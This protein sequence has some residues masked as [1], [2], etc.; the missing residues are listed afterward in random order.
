MNMTQF[1]I[2]RKIVLHKTLASGISFSV[3]SLNREMAP[4]RVLW[5]LAQKTHL[6]SLKN[7]CSKW[8]VW[9]WT[10]FER[11]NIRF[12]I[13]NILCKFKGSLLN[14]YVMWSF[15][16]LLKKCSPTPTTFEKMKLFI[17]R[18]TKFLDLQETL[19]PSIERLFRQLN[20]GS[21]MGT[22]IEPFLRILLWVCMR[23]SVIQRSCLLS[24]EKMIE[25]GCGITCTKNLPQL[26]S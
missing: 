1:C 11:R 15:S 17:H 26:K 16:K 8:C 23:G 19:E 3:D 25:V 4:E 13:I 18:H 24:V 12:H 7:D 2:S 21:S 22:F 9:M 6:S 10:T 14:C 20:R 5:E